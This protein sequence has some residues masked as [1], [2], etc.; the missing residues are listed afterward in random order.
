MHARQLDTTL[1][2]LYFC[3]LHWRPSECNSSCRADCSDFIGNSSAALVYLNH[4][5]VSATGFSHEMPKFDSS[6]CWSGWHLHMHV[7]SCCTQAGNTD[8]SCASA[9][10][11]RCRYS[12]PDHCQLMTHMCCCIHYTWH[13]KPKITSA[14]QKF[15]FL[16]RLDMACFAPDQLI[17]LTSLFNAREYTGYKC[18]S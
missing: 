12:C 1:Q 13:A 10:Y 8:T 17:A 15:T 9:Y 11:C 6:Y 5:N 4:L 7:Y 18:N 16:D 2:E 3:Y 14:D